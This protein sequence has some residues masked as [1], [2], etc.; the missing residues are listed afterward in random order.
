MRHGMSL[1]EM[2]CEGLPRRHYWLMVIELDD[3]VPCRHPQMPNLY[4][5][6]TLSPPDERFALIQRSRKKYWYTDH[7]KQLR[8]DLAPAENFASE[9]EARRRCSELIRK[10]ASDGYTVNRDA[11]VWNVYVIELDPSAVDDPGKG[12][13]YVGETS[14]TP[15]ERF[16]QHRTGARNQRG[17]LFST[18]VRRHGIRLR[19]DLAPQE[20]YFDS[21]SAKRAEKN[22]FEFLKSMGFIVKG[23][24]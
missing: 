4:V 17:P 12:H 21:V 23:G 20:R 9:E 19:P 14:R 5:G 6:K 15:E 2:K 3:V 8:R 18:V 13:V 22:H 1:S 10:L 7:L 16:E 11:R 24:R